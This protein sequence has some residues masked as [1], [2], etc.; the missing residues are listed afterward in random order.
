MPNLATPNKQAVYLKHKYQSHIYRETNWMQYRTTIRPWKT[1][2]GIR[3][4]FSCMICQH[5]REYMQEHGRAQ[6]WSQFSGYMSFLS[7][8]NG[9]DCGTSLSLY[10]LA[11]VQLS[12]KYLVFRCC[13]VWLHR[14]TYVIKSFLFMV[15]FF[16]RYSNHSDCRPVDRPDKQICCDQNLNVGRP[17]YM[18]S[19]FYLISW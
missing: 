9:L 17:H 11:T 8:L 10:I 2:S 19:D 15:A 6:E 5:A 18:I 12:P 7:R 4:S 13:D 14:S 3:P 1:T 16:I